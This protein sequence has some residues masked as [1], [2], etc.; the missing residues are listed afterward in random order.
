MDTGSDG[1][2]ELVSD[3]AGRGLGTHDVLL[4]LVAHLQLS[5]I[6]GWALPLVAPVII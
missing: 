2:L 5:R 3:R 1:L 4:M 6:Q